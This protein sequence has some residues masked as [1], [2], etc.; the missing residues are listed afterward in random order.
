MGIGVAHDTKGA[1]RE[2]G[3]AAAG[4]DADTDI[5]DIAHARSLVPASD[6]GAA[7][8]RSRIR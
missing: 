3:L 8:A 7:A 5:G 2:P 6:R 1:R 4:R